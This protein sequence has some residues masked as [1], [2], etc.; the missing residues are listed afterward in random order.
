MSFYIVLVFAV[1]LSFL[2]FLI[3]LYHSSGIPMTVLK[4]IEMMKSGFLIKNINSLMLSR[5]EFSDNSY[6]SL[7]DVLIA[8]NVFGDTEIFKKFLNIRKKLKEDK[9]IHFGF[10][11]IIEGSCYECEEPFI[12]PSKYGDLIICR[13]DFES[14]FGIGGT[15]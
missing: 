8:S 11:N 2:V 13:V 6:V 7:M 1:L 14:V 9:K 3:L 12:F 15:C 10:C 4:Q 5:V